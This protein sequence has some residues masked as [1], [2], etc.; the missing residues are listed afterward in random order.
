MDC[1]IASLFTPFTLKSITP[2]NR[3]VAAPMCQYMANDGLLDKWR[4]F[5]SPV[6]AWGGVG[7]VIV[8]ATAVSPQGL[9]T[10]GDAACGATPRCRALPW[11]R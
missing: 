1:P 9:I 6:L 11:W 2:R 3:L 5:H 10:P 4:Q 8:E 7:L